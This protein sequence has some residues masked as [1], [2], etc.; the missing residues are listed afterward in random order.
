MHIRKQSFVFGSYGEVEFQRLFSRGHNGSQQAKTGQSLSKLLT[1][2]VE[3]N[4]YLNP[5]GLISHNLEIVI[6]SI[7]SSYCHK[8]IYL[9]VFLNKND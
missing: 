5:F 1:T 9:N 3:I 6:S 8:V 2:E 4:V 7:F